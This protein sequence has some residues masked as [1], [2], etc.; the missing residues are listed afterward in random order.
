MLKVVR[1]ETVKSLLEIELEVLGDRWGKKIFY[2]IL[3][4]V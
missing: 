2:L 4:D 3:K 1:M